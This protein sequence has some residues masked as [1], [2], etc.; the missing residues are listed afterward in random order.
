[1]D[2]VGEV[3]IGF[4]QLGYGGSNRGGGDVAAEGALADVGDELVPEVLECAEGVDDAV[5]EGG[6]DELDLLVE[7]DATEE[8][9]V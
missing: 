3:G 9:A 5:G 6:G 4:E 7:N 2:C 8:V 1:M